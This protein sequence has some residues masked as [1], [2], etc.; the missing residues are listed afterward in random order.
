MSYTNNDTTNFDLSI[1]DDVN[2]SSVSNRQPLDDISNKS[3]R[4]FGS[5]G[6]GKNMQRVLV[7]NEMKYNKLKGDYS[8]TLTEENIQNIENKI[9]ERGN[10]SVKDSGM[11]DPQ[12]MRIL[13]SNAKSAYKLKKGG[14]R[15]TRRRRKSIYRKRINSRR[16]KRTRRI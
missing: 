2:T 1:Y 16:R 13:I 8:N 12:A 14:M 7:N 15:R 6:Y 3:D 11:D 4:I 5:L 9:R 10:Q